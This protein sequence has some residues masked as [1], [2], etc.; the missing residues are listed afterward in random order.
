MLHEIAVASTQVESEDE[1]LELATEIIG[2]NLFPDNF[3]ILLLDEKSGLLR[4]HPSYRVYN[5]TNLDPLNFVVS[6]GK[7]VSGQVAQSGTSQRIGDV[8]QI[9]NYLDVDARTR[10]ELCVPLKVKERVIGVINAESMELN[11][12]TASDEALVVTFAGQLATALEYLRTLDAE[13]QWMGR[14]ARSN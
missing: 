11:A 4:A 10:S 14:L 1:L 5:S 3:G 6:L 12:F 8:R 2:R 9:E 7:G 13:R